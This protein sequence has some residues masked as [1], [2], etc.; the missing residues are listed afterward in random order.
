MRSKKGAASRKQLPRRYQLH[1]PLHR[2]NRRDREKPRESRKAT[3]ERLGLD[4]LLEIL[5]PV[6]FQCILALG[7]GPDN[8]QTQPEGSCPPSSACGRWIR[9]GRSAGHAPRCDG[10]PRSRAQEGAAPRPR[11]P[12]F[13]VAMRATRRRTTRNRPGRPGSVP[14]RGGSRH[15]PSGS[16][17]ESRCSSPRRES[18]GSGSFRH[19]AAP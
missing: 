19:R 12:G 14:H 7:R 15:G 8:R 5:L 13:A 1:E 4:L 3:H 9:T 10:A 18:A 6:G 11:R 2:Q 17:R 16:S